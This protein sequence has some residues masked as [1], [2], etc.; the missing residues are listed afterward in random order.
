MVGHRH[1]PALGE[2]GGDQE[3]LE[4][5]DRARRVRVASQ[6]IGG[7]AARSD[8]VDRALVGNHRRD[9]RGRALGGHDHR[10]RGGIGVAVHVGGA[11]QQLGGAHA[12]RDQAHEGQLDVAAAQDGS[13]GGVLEAG[14]RFVERIIGRQ[15]RAGTAYQVL[16]GDVPDPLCTSCWRDAAQI[17]PAI[18]T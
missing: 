18:V 5:R 6:G 9:G 10:G 15:L 2:A 14:G 4:L 7:E 1:R 11:I 13:R 12:L 16:V 8:G 3:E 17:H